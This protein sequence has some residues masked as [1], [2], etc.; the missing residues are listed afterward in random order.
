ML[1]IKTIIHIITIKKNIK[2]I[3]KICCFKYL[4]KLPIT[5]M[6]NMLWLIIFFRFR[7]EEFLKMFSN[8]FSKDMLMRYKKKIGLEQ[9]IKEKKTTV[10]TLK[11]YF[12]FD[13]WVYTI[14]YLIRLTDL[15]V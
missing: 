8:R 5:N 1:G 3:Y 15:A 6:G 11:V 4:S 2:T 14:F 10:E 12:K 7:K 9:S 13:R